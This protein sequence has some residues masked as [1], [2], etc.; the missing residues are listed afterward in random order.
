MTDKQDEEWLAVIM[1]QICVGSNETTEGL[2][3]YCVTSL[4]MRFELTVESKN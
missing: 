2:L 3:L 1:G 4:W